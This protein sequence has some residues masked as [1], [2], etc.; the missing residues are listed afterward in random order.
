MAEQIRA[1]ERELVAPEQVNRGLRI[2]HLWWDPVCLV[3]FVVVRV[4]RF[5]F[6]LPPRG[7]GVRIGALPPIVD[8]PHPCGADAHCVNHSRAVWRL[9]RVLPL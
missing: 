1:Q 2:D 7:D 6:Q 9:A 5:L 4:L 8:M 3:F